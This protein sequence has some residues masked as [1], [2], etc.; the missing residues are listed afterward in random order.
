[1]YFALEYNNEN[2]KVQEFI[3]KYYGKIISDSSDSVP[4]DSDI[5]ISHFKDDCHFEELLTNLK[6]SKKHFNV[7]WIET[8]SPDKNLLIKNT[9]LKLL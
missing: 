9:N 3:D 6:N 8:Y 2:K 1:M 4:T 5:Y 7:Y